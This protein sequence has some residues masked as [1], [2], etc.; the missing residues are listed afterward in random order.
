MLCMSRCP[1]FPVPRSAPSVPALL[2][3]STIAGP[4]IVCLPMGRL[5][6]AG[7]RLGT[8]GPCPHPVSPSCPAPLGSA[9]LLF[10]CC[11]G[12]CQAG[13]PWAPR[14]C[15]AGAPAGWG[16]QAPGPSDSPCC[17]MVVRCRGCHHR[18]V[19][20]V[21]ERGETGAGHWH[22]GVLSLPIPVGCRTE[23]T[24]TLLPVGPGLGQSFCFSHCQL[25]ES[26]KPT[27]LPGIETPATVPTHCTGPVLCPP[28]SQ[29]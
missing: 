27:R 9:R 21:G 10:G 3:V 16:S 20:P 22:L 23:V 13:S 19:T 28:P 8:L 12:G 5:R 15:S 4:C 11:F 18:W 14:P 25:K 17:P 26:Q 7:S 1:P 29:R 24:L 2:S 6:W